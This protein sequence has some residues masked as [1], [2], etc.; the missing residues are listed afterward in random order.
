MRDCTKRRGV[1]VSLENSGSG[2]QFWKNHRTLPFVGDLLVFA[3][4]AFLTTYLAWQR[5]FPYLF[6][7]EYGV[8]GAAAVLSGL[9]WV[10][11]QDMPFYGFVLSLLVAPFYKLDLD[12]TTLY[13]VALSINGIFVAASALLALHTVR[14]VSSETPETVAIVAVLAAFSYPAVVFYAGLALGE[15]ALLFSLMLTIYG[16]ARISQ[17]QKADLLGGMLFG[18]G[19]ALAPYAHSRGLVFSLAALPVMLIALK[20]KWVGP[21]SMIAA[22]AAAVPIV[23]VLSTVKSWLMTHF[24]SVVRA[25]TGS[26]TDFLENKLFAVLAPDNWFNLGL[27]AYGQFAY[28]A[29]ATFGLLL[30]GVVGII[31]AL[32]SL[33]RRATWELSAAV[34]NDAARSRV[35]V[36]GFSMLA[37]LGM[38]VLSTITLTG[39]RADHFFYGRYNEVMAPVVIAAGIILLNGVY[40]LKRRLAIIWFGVAGGI[41]V[42]SVFG[43]EVFPREIFDRPMIWNSLSAWHVHIHGEWRIE[44]RII[45]IGTGAAVMLLWAALMVSRR[46]FAVVVASM[47]MAGTLHNYVVQH[48]G[49]DRAW[50]IYGAF[51]KEYS[52]VL[53]DLDILNR[54]E[55]WRLQGDARGLQ[56]ALPH[57]RMH[58]ARPE[59]AQL[60]IMVD[61]SGEDCDEGD[62]I[63]VS[64]AVQLCIYD[65]DLFG[66][67]KARL[68]MVKRVPSARTAA[69]ARIELDRS[70]VEAGGVLQRLCAR[71]AQYFYLGWAR[72][73]LPSVD[74]KVW[75]GGL[76]GEERQQLGV[77]VTD[78]AGKW[79]GEWRARLDTRQL[80]TGKEVNVRIPIRFPADLPAGNY[81]MHVTVFDEEGWDWRSRVSVDLVVK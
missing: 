51:G 70:V 43:I 19:L 9:E 26:A 56:F 44:P 54:S 59:I 12:P 46:G 37:L 17:Q 60:Q 65:K 41:T 66:E 53:S 36:A 67:A 61:D 6:D 73:C 32:V 68:G 49:A 27:V 18:T 58:F 13:R 29:S 16:L 11:P 55:S 72:H 80:A 71:A 30:V 50:G 76:S 10:T 15:T 48:G 79:L 5:V 2:K 23:L 33:R 20:A 24:Y 34:G 35:V 77:F 47:F 62:A 74:A 14:R 52:D 75:R 22:V 81:T 8:L 21:V 4:F 7:D 42:L 57:S 38:M 1:V 63:A 69:A 25:G 45:A 3:W 28:F 64:A 40:G 39:A 78:A 31:A